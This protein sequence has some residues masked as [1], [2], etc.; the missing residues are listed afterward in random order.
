[1]RWQQHGREGAVVVDAPMAI[2]LGSGPANGEK[3]KI[4]GPTTAWLVNIGSPCLR[5]SNLLSS[6]SAARSCP[7]TPIMLLLRRM[8]TGGSLGCENNGNEKRRRVGA[9]V[10]GSLRTKYGLVA[11]AWSRDV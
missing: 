11:L 2:V 10:Y 4:D 9:S 8:I 7:E 3:R 1:M 6:H 5:R